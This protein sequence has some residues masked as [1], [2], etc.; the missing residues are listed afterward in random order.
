MIGS[1]ELGCLSGLVDA[2]RRHGKQL[3]ERI[4]ED[5]ELAVMQ[6]A[7]E[8]ISQQRTQR[9][10]ATHTV[11]QVLGRAGSLGGQVDRQQ[12]ALVRDRNA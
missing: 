2:Y 3:T 7:L 5:V 1:H 12:L 8:A 10:P 6:P 9:L 11:Q 4:D